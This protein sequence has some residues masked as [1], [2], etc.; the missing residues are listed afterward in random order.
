V[1]SKR[2]PPLKRLLLTKMMSTLEQKLKPR[3]SAELLCM[4]AVSTSESCDGH[5]GRALNPVIAL[6]SC[7]PMARWEAGGRCPSP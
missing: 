7:C 4:L 3:Y 5:D 1:N 6:N 2:S